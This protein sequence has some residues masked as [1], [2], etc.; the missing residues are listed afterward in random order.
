MVFGG[1]I[2][3]IGFVSLIIVFD[4]VVNFIR[5]CIDMV[6]H[7]GWGLVF[8]PCPER[9]PTDLVFLPWVSFIRF[10]FS[11]DECEDGGHHY[12]IWCFCQ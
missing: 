6:L 9:R 3:F 12:W 2:Q 10:G 7:L 5:G 4:Y 8:L 1:K 11:A